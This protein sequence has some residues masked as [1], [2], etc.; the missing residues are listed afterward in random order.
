MKAHQI[1]INKSGRRGTMKHE[2]TEEELI[3]TCISRYDQ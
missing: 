2:R 1:I 3:Q